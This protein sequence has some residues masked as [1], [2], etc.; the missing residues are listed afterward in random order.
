MERFYDLT[1][2]GDSHKKIYA[3][4]V[5]NGFRDDRIITV[6]NNDDHMALNASYRKEDGFDFGHNIRRVAHMDLGT[7]R[8]LAKRKPN[9]DEDAIKYL[10]YHDTEARDRLIRRYPE[11]FKACSGGV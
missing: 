8:L 11:F 7:I 10:E 2:I 6:G 3:T 5:V 1:D 4:D 9:P